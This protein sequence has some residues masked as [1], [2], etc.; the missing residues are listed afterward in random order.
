MLWVE[1]KLLKLEDRE[2][3]DKDQEQDKGL[4]VDKLRPLQCY[5]VMIHKEVAV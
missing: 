1:D 4:L 5:I 2:L 3:T